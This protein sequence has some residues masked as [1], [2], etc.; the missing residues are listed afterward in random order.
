MWRKDFVAIVALLTFSIG[1]SGVEA[2][3][4]THQIVAGDTI[5]ADVDIDESYSGSADLKFCLADYDYSD[6]SF[7]YRCDHFLDRYTIEFTNTFHKRYIFSTEGIEPQIYRLFVQL[8]YDDKYRKDCDNDNFVYIGSSSEPIVYVSSPTGVRISVSNVSSTYELG[9]VVSS[10]VNIT[11]FE[12]CSTFN[13]QSYLF[14]WTE[15]IISSKESYD[16]DLSYGLSTQLNMTNTIF[17]SI[18]SGDYIYKVLVR[19]CSN[20]YYWSK[21]IKVVEK[22]VPEVNVT[23]SN[24]TIY[25]KNFD[26]TNVSFSISIALPNTSYL[27]NLTL[28]PHHQR[29]LR[30]NRTDQF[31]SIHYGKIVKQFFIESNQTCNILATNTNTTCINSSYHLS[32]PPSTSDFVANKEEKSFYIVSLF[33][34]LGLLFLLYKRLRL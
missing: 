14:G 15:G 7:N 4:L 16:I 28:L 1:F 8:H 13:V 34:S 30:L 22:A 19:G 3:V 29:I 32:I 27:F 25:L 23:L 18:S 5:V 24:Y 31:V 2:V 10:F 9:S 12:N 11:N 33:S 20:S 21:P 26:S 17:D 6:L